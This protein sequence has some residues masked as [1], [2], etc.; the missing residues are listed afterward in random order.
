MSRFWSFE[1]RTAFIFLGAVAARAAFH[2]LTRFTADDAFITF[3]FAENLAHGFGFVYNQGQH[4]LGTTTPLFTFLLATLNIAHLPVQVS[5]LAVSLLAAGTTAVLLY[6]MALR[7]RFTRFAL[8]APLAYILWP[9]SLAAETCGMEAALFTAFIVAAFFFQ[10]RQQG[11]YALGCATLATMTRPEG[12]WLLVLV[13]AA[14]VYLDRDRWLSLSIVPLLVLVPWFVFSW[15]YFG[16]PMPHAVTAKLALYSQFGSG[17]WWSR[18][19][20]IMGWR[21]PA[22]WIATP[23]AI[24]GAVWLYRKQNWGRLAL[25]WLGGMMLFYTISHTRLFFWY[26]TP[27]HP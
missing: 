21:N 27:L 22:G 10:M 18:L 20:F 13:L 5:A 4:V 26:L 1:T 2:N 16:S 8:L 15:L 9:R 6:R 23:L 11:F 25:L 24:Y 3:R 7:L 17:S 19:V 12:A 14:N